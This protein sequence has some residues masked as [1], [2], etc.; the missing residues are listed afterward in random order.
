MTRL[1]ADYKV[2]G[3]WAKYRGSYA[4][5]TQTLSSQIWNAM[6][7][8]CKAGARNPSYAGCSISENFKDFQFF[9]EWCQHQIGYSKKNSDGKHWSLEK[10][11]L[12]RGN[13][14]Y[15]EDVC[16]FLPTEI[17]NLLL[18]QSGKRGAWPI[19]VH[20]SKEKDVFVAQLNSKG[21]RWH[22]GYF[23]TP[24]EAFERYKFAKESHIRDM[25]TK[26]RCEIDSRAF[27][28]L[29]TYGILESQ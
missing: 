18:L 8:R 5:Q 10:D 12:V 29:M 3:L 26:W 28:A 17:N 9:A 6:H 14:M 20:Y 27:D 16:V 22:L 23:K 24:E 7:I 25:A 1:I 11:L 13:R 2:D 19:G 21:K 4:E 15:S